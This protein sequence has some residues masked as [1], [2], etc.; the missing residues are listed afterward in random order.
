MP[1]KFTLELKADPPAQE[2]SNNLMTSRIREALLVLLLVVSH[3][4]AAFGNEL[5]AWETFRDQSIADNLYCV[6]GICSSDDSNIEFEI[7]D[8]ELIADLLRGPVPSAVLMN[9]PFA[10]SQECDGT[11]PYA[12]KLDGECV[13]ICHQPP[14][15]DQSLQF[16]VDPLAAR[17][18][19]ATV[20]DLRARRQIRCI[21]ISI[22]HFK[23]ALFVF[24]DAIKVIG[25]PSS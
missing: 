10:R 11:E 24:A 12:V 20:G 23:G 1:T 6:S 14:S 25:H 5:L 19:L 22:V 4:Q 3:A 9:P 16:H 13:K 21:G 8:G 15:F 18:G 2:R 17:I 7:R